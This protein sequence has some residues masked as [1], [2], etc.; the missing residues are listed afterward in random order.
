MR[1]GLRGTWVI[2]WQKLVAAVA[3]DRVA[4]LFLFVLPLGITVVVGAASG[5]GGRI[6]LAVVEPRDAAI[7]RALHRELEASSAL[8]VSWHRRPEDAERRLARQEVG[9][10]LSVARV[11]GR[12]AAALRVD[13]GRLDPG[14]VSGPLLGALGAVG[15]DLDGRRLTV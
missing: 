15:R 2:A 3:R 12:T 9:A 1:A 6:A 4:Q 14:L 10:V 7:A 8:D 13:R 5:A 11:D